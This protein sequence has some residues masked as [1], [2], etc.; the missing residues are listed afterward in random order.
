MAEP[1]RVITFNTAVGNPR[2]KTEQR[3]FLELPFYREILAGLPEAAILALQEVGAEQAKALEQAARAGRFRLV[4][5][6][7]PGQGNALLIPERF[8][9]LGA[10]SH[11]FVR[12][13]VVAM[14]KALW[15]RLRGGT[16]PNHRQL[17]ELRMWSEARVRDERTQRVF[18][19]FNTHIS[20]D[21]DLRLEQ[22][23]DLFERVHAA[24]RRGPVILAG[25]LNTRAAEEPRRPDHPADAA[26]RR[27]FE[28]L[29]DMG[30]AAAHPGGRSPIDYV[31]AAGF[32]PVAARLYTGNSL[33]LPGLPTADLI[34]DHYA[35]EV[36]IA[37]SE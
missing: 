33:Q 28:G 15:R 9:V 32:A 2:I 17:G 4:Q 8:A 26:I 24:R 23:R 21:A 27:L 19:I 22:V 35:K 14:G 36:L 6:R 20:G 16:R 34:S 11:Y 25:D 12:A 5:K 18:S 31:L 3:A 37:S 7:R 1:F 30:A 13:Q 29:S 10:R